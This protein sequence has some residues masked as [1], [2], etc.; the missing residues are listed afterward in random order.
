MINL[1]AACGTNG[2]MGKDGRL[3]WNIPKDWEYFLETTRNG[4]LIMGRRCFA[5]MGSHV[6][7]RKVIALSRN[8]DMKFKG[9][10]KASSLQEALKMSQ[11]ETI[12]IC[13][14]QKIYEESM[15]IAERLYLTL[16]GSDFDGD[17][18]FPAWKEIFSKEISRKTCV[19]SGYQLTFLILGRGKQ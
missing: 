7:D 4:T 11:G 13:G 9:A 6:L 1:I 2:V 15:P 18:R 12:W 16:I 3:P 8:P 5:E 10:E 19:D 14:G 17:V